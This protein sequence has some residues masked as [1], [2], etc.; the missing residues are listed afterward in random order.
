MSVRGAPQSFLS[1]HEDIQ[2][3]RSDRRNDSYGNYL[4][5]GLC[6]RQNRFT[7]LFPIRLLK[8]RIGKKIAAAE[9]SASVRLSRARAGH[10]ARQALLEVICVNATPARCVC[11][12]LSAGGRRM[13][14]LLVLS[15]ALLPR[16]P[17]CDSSGSGCGEVND[18]A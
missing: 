3:M 13:P 6:P 12:R 1:G 18:D 2:N 11:S 5:P 10:A 7:F 15:K 17:R 8:L 4:R 14:A 9:L 16:K